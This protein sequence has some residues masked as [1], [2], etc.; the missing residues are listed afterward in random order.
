MG[1]VVVV[2]CGGSSWLGT[3]HGMEIYHPVSLGSWSLK[4]K[5]EKNNKHMSENCCKKKRK[6]GRKQNKSASGGTC[7]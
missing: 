6:K 5:E 2:V 4:W 1:V 7:L 3:V